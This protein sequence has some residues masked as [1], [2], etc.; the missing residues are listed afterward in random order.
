MNQSAV[1]NALKIKKANDVAMISEMFSSM[2]EKTELQSFSA[3][4][5]VSKAS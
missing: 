1:H 5:H 4:S 2:C 3:D